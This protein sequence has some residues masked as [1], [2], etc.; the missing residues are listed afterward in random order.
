MSIIIPDVEY[1]D[2]EIW[3]MQIDSPFSV[4]NETRTLL[5]RIPFCNG[6]YDS[7]VKFRELVLKAADALRDAYSVW[8]EDGIGIE[9]RFKLDY[10][11]C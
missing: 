2:A 5:T 8:G 7:G 9:V 1:A 10:V 3:V 11:N 6:E 4:D